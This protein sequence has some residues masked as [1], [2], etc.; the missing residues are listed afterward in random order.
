MTPDELRIWRESHLW[1]GAQAARY[2]GVSTA[3]Y[4]NWE[5]GRR[6]PPAILV[7]LIDVLRTVEC[8]APAIHAAMVPPAPALRQ[9]RVTN[10][11]RN[12]AGARSG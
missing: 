4:R 5:S 11:P 12:S 3:T 2:V 1:D 10:E 6:K 8:L 7:R 9:E